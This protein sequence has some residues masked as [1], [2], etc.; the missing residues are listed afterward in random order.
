MKGRTYKL[1]GHLM[2][3]QVSGGSGVFAFVMALISAQ[4]VH[5]SLILDAVRGRGVVAGWRRGE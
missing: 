3:V 1:D 4:T 2:P 5:R